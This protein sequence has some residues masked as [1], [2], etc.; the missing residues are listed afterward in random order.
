MVWPGILPLAV[1]SIVSA[2]VVVLTGDG[3]TGAAVLTPLV[4]AGL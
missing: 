2:N 4:H 3:G 1:V